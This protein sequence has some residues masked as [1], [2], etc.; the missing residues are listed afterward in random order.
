VSARTTNAALDP[1]PK[2]IPELYANLPKAAVKELARLFKAASKPG[3]PEDER[4]RIEQQMFA[5]Q[6][7]HQPRRGAVRFSGREIEALIAGLR[8][9][10]SNDQRAL[11]IMRLRD[12]KH[13]GEHII[14]E[15]Q[16]G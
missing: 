3:L 2:F 12:L 5:I 1:G 9:M 8:R 15:R 6:R 7:K 14:I 11:L 10:R 13:D 16:G 4:A